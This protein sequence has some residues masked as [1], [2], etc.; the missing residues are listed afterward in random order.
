LQLIII[1]IMITIMII[2]IIIIIIINSRIGINR[3]YWLNN[4]DNGEAT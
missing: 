4:T 3:K 2:I 1:I